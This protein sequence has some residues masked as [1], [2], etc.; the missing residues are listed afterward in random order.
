M[1]L[2]AVVLLLAYLP[3]NALKMYSLQSFLT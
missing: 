1:I 3:Q 2:V